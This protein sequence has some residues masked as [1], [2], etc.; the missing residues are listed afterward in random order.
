VAKPGAQT[1]IGIQFDTDKNW[2]M[3]WKNSGDSGEPPRVRWQLPEGVTAGALEWPSPTRLSNSAGTDYGYEGNVVLLSTLNIPAT[4]E[5]GGNLAVAGDLRWLVCH[6]ICIPQRAEL[7]A[8]M[9]IANTATVDN[10][11][12]VLLDAAAE[13]MPKPLP[14]ALHLTATSTHDTLRL[15]FVSKNKAS[16]GEASNPKIASAVFFPSE[17]EQIDNAAPQ[18]FAEA[19][20]MVRLELKKSDHLQRDPERLEGVLVLNQRDSYQVDVPVRKP[21]AHKERR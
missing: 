20:G 11:A 3:Y 2:H 5:P 8:A 1:R 13:R 19:G 6:D 9:R 7:K 21:A 14:E 15:S 12:H 17:P 16:S 18:E 10:R 4:A